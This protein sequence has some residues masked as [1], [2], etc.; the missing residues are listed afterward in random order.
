MPLSNSAAADQAKELLEFRQAEAGRL[1]EI[2]EY[3]RDDPERR[4]PGLPA[5]VPREVHQLARI[6]RVNFLRFVVASRVQSMYV[7]G[8]RT[9]RASDDAPAWQA[10]QAN[11]MDARQIGIH[12]A[13]LSYGAAYMTVLPGDPVPVMRGV[14]PRH[15]TAVYGDDDQW[16]VYALQK[17]RSDWRLFDDQAVYT[18]VKDGDGFRVVSVAEHGAQMDGRPVCPVVRY[19]DT[20]DL[21]DPVTGIV[22]PL[23]SLQDQIN[24]TS[25]ELQV[26]QHYG[27][28]RVRYVIGWLAE[29]EQQKLKM[30]ASSLL[31]FEDS[32]SDVQVGEFAE[33]NLKGY[34]DSREASLR[35]LATISQTA[36]HE[37]LGQLINLSAEALAAAEA[38]HRRAVSEN[39]MCI[40]E[41]HEQALRLAG[42]YM[43]QVPD[44]AAS[45]RW[46]DTESRSLA[47]VADALGKLAAQLGIPPQELW[48]RIPGV[49]DDE[50]DRWRA[51]AERGDAL[52]NLAALLE[53]Q[54]APDPAEAAGGVA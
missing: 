9:P 34:I 17:R 41:S 11:G 2:R 5:G 16:P 19:R 27:A 52:G 40:G 37:L 8:F 3:L 47:Q 25:F 28:F 20:D 45:V 15:L 21:D 39:Q 31:T 44:A 4:L 23:R 43:G 14:S 53:R 35:H 6:S 13:A 7:D 48:E 22:W 33:T 50:L 36:A 12:R 32:P 54:A 29:S 49:T 1:E 26:A 46:R 51:A 42:T 18:L 30:T 38:S 24:A 10:W